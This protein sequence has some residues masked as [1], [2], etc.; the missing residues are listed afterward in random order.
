MGE[1]LLNRIAFGLLVVTLIFGVAAF[2]Y[3]DTQAP[4]DEPI[5]IFYESK[6]GPVIFDHAAHSARQEDCWACHHMDGDEAEK[7]NCKTCH[8]ENE[9]PLIHE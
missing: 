5:R 3:R 8:E 1:N 6:G 9:I 7:D 4:P 2:Y